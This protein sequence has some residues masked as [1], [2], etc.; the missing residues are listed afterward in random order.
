MESKRER[1]FHSD[2]IVYFEVKTLIR[3]D[4]TSDLKETPVAKGN[5][6]SA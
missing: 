4:S 6:I 2:C 5:S 3:L 1:R